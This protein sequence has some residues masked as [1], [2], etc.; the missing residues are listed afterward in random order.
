MRRSIR[1]CCPHVVLGVQRNATK[2]EI[3]DA[4]RKSAKKHHPDA[5]GSREEFHKARNAFEELMLHRKEGTKTS[6]Y[7]ENIASARGHHY[8]GAYRTSRVR[9]EW[10][11]PGTAYGTARQTQFEGAWHKLFVKIT[12]LTIFGTIFAYGIGQ[13]ID[14]DGLSW[15]E[16]PHP[17][18]LASRSSERLT[19]TQKLALEKSLVKASENTPSRNKVG[20]GVN[21]PGIGFLNYATNTITRSP[22][23]LKVIERANRPKPVAKWKLR[24][25]RTPTSLAAAIPMV[26]PSPAPQA[27]GDTTETEMYKTKIKELQEQL[28]VLEKAAAAVEE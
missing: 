26:R 10:E 5:G 25:E 16:R 3:K 17:A 18:I 15:L 23:Y 14:E 22:E 9:P 7:D 21:A 6:S 27:E 20:N 13:D 4:F 12:L 24:G 19:Y 28:K 1:R 8:Y 11:E 2:E